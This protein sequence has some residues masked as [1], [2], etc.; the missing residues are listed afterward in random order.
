MSD[1][2]EN[3]VWYKTPCEIVRDGT[4]TLPP[5]PLRRLTA[6]EWETLFN[7]GLPLFTWANLTDTD[8]I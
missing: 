4:F 3:L 5:G 1:L 2:T 7:N 6:D 8:T